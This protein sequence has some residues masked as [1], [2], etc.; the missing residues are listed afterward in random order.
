MANDERSPARRGD[1]FR[2]KLAA[3]WPGLVSLWVIVAGWLALSVL[4]VSVPELIFGPDRE[5]ALYVS[6]TAAVVAATAWLAA[7]P[8]RK[9][10][11]LPGQVPAET[12]TRKPAT[13]P[14]IWVAKKEHRL[15]RPG[16]SARG[17]M[18]Q[19]SEAEYA[20]ADLL[21][22]LGDLP[23]VPNEVVEDS[24][25]AAN[26]T[27]VKLRSMAARFEAVE[28][29]AEHAPPHERVTLQDGAGSLLAHVH[30]G[31]EAYRGL[32]AA[33]GRVALAA[34]SAPSTDELVE[35]TES[36]TGLAEALDEL[37]TVRPIV[38]SE[39]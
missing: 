34:T 25:H 29:A 8:W 1:R 24:W 16:S 23:A 10:D 39:T 30:Q 33:A 37:A 38:G 22:R 11:P 17:P 36:L 27:A 6:L 19:L 2:A 14:G 13:P 26:E 5:G 21:R 4:A 18:R 32:I 31:V 7:R 20:L 3:L 9:P 35:A 12:L 28:I 15:P